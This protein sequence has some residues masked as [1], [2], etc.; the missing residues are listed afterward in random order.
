M[1]EKL[2]T[3]IRLTL[4]CVYLLVVSALLVLAVE[5]TIRLL[6]LQ[7]APVPTR[8]GLGLTGEMLVSVV[9]AAVLFALVFRRPRRLLAVSLLALLA[10]VGL[11][12]YSGRHV[13]PQVL[14][15]PTPVS[16]AERYTQALAADDLDAALRLTDRSDSC[17]RIMSQAFRDHQA[18]LMQTLG[19]DWKEVGMTTVSV[20]G[21]TTVYEDH[22][23]YQLATVRVETEGDR[24]A[25]LTVQMQYGPFLGT[26]YICGK[27]LNSELPSPPSKPESTPALAGAL[28][29][30]KAGRD[31]EAAH[32]TIRE[33]PIVAAE[34][35]GPGRFEYDDQLGDE[36]RT[37]IEALRDR[38]TELSLVQTNAALAPFGYRLE[39]RFDPECNRTFY[40][41]YHKGESEPLLPGLHPSGR[42]RSTIR[43][44]TLA[45]RWRTRPMPGPSTCWS[46]TARF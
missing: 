40:D 29:P 17:T 3:G 15:W 36:V 16:L 5:Q 45:W 13:L 11:N 24:S 10:F 44:A 25:W 37:R 31:V 34:V 26:R 2:K 18:R 12:L 4:L 35:M 9:T 30:E 41:F 21:I 1:T 14:I 33:S 8:L 19:E 42:S 27:K 28:P 43:A 23:P 32:L 6:R 38:S 7:A 20:N 22:F 46:A 39:S